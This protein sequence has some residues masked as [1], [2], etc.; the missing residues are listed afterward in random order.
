MRDNK[1]VKNNSSEFLGLV[2]AGNTCYMNSFL[3]TLYHLSCFARIVYKVVDNSDPVYQIGSFFSGEIR[4][5][6]GCSA[7][8]LL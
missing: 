6:F 2:N 7:K 4:G 3:Q 1:S 8:A 5:Y